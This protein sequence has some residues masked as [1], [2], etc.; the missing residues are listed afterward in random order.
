MD[1]DVV[2]FVLREWR[3]ILFFLTG[4]LGVW[5]TIKENVWCWPI[6]LIAVVVCLVEFYTSKLYGD[7]GL[8]VVY[9]FAGI[10]GWIYWE[11]NKHA[12]FLVKHMSLRL[13]PLLVIITV[14]QAVLY[15]YLLIYF[16][17]DRP[18]V[19]GTLTACSLTV[20]YLM[21]KKWVENWLFWV[22]IDTAYVLLYAVKGLWFFAALSVIQTVLAFYGWLKWRK[23]AL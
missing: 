13:I 4:S 17:G 7:M 1:F 11:R 5:L 16:N 18:L 15:Y 8:Q 3:G 20:T 22:I 12:V 21:T 19:D 2:A 23:E 14:A 6:S 10:Y 9:F